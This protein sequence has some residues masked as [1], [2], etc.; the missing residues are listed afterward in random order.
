LHK[1]ALFLFQ[2]FKELFG[3]KK[4][5]HF[6]FDWLY[7]LSLNKTQ[8]FRLENQSISILFIIIFICCIR[9]IHNFYLFYFV[10]FNFLA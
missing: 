5:S 9:V 8:H 6:D 10:I 7:I 4:A 3:I 1:A 2:H